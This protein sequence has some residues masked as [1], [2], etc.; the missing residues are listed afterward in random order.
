MMNRFFTLL[1]AASCSTAV[2]QQ[3]LADGLFAWY[4]FEGDFDNI[5]APEEP[6]LATNVDFVLDEDGQN[7]MG[8]FNGESSRIELQ[9]ANPQFCLSQDF[10]ISCRIKINAGD[11]L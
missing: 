10:T 2:G 6:E 4:D 1:L 7:Q 9:S 8:M 5:V 11:N 3:S